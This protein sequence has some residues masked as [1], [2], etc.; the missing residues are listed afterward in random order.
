MRL[1]INISI[2][3]FVSLHGIHAKEVKSSLS[4]ITFGD[5]LDNGVTTMS[6]VIS[7]FDQYDPTWNEKFIVTDLHQ[8]VR[9][10]INPFDDV[11]IDFDVDVELSFSYKHFSFPD[12]IETQKTHTLKVNYKKDAHST[13]KQIDV[14]KLL[15]GQ[16]IEIYNIQFNVGNLTQSEIDKLKSILVLKAYTEDVR[17]YNTS[18]ISLIDDNDINVNHNQIKKEL[19]ITW[20]L[21]EAAEEYDIR[22]KFVDNYNGINNNNGPDPIPNIDLSL[23]FVPESLFRDMTRLSTSKNEITIPAIEEKSLFIVS[24]RA[25]GRMG[26]DYE[27]RFEGPWSS[28]YYHWMY[29]DEHVEDKI[30]YQSITSYAEEGKYKIVNQY[31]DGRMASRQKVT[32]LQSKEYALVQESIYDHI[33]RLAIEVL[34]APVRGP[35]SSELGSIM[36]YD[37]FNRNP[38]DDEPYHAVNF[39]KVGCLSDPDAMSSITS[40]ASHYYSSAF[41]NSLSS[42]EKESELKLIPDAFERPF[43]QTRFMNDNTNRPLAQGGVGK[44]H[45]LGTGRETEITYTTPTQSELN[46][47][48]GTEVGYSNY[49]K[50]VITED[51]NNQ[52]SIAYQDLKGNT[53]ATSLYGATDNLDTLETYKK[54]SFLDD[55]TVNDNIDYD[56]YSIEMS[57]PLF[58][59]ENN[60]SYDFNYSLTPAQFTDQTC[61]G[62]NV[63]YDCIYDLIIEITNTDCNEKILRLTQSIGFNSNQDVD[64][65]CNA[66]IWDAEVELHVGDIFR[67]PNQQD[68]LILNLILNK[69][70]YV[71]NKILK[72]NEVAADQYVD[73][74]VNDPNNT[75]IKT[76]VEWLQEQEDE[77]LDA[78]CGIDCDQ[79]DPTDELLVELCDSTNNKCKMAENAMISDFMPGGQYAIYNVNAQGEYE[80]SNALSIFAPNNVLDNGGPVDFVNIIM[81]QFAADLGGMDL[82]AVD[83]EDIITVLWQPEWSAAFLPFHPEF[84]YLQHCND[85]SA[86]YDG[87]MLTIETAAQAIAQGYLDANNPENILHLLDN[88][89]FFKDPLSQNLGCTMPGLTGSDFFFSMQNELNNF[90]VNYP[91]HLNAPVLSVYDLA[92][93][94]VCNG[95]AFDTLTNTIDPTILQN[96]QNN[97]SFTSTDPELANMLWIQIRSIY[98]SIKEKY[99]Y[100]TRSINAINDGCYN[101]C[102][103]ESPFN[104]IRNNFNQDIAINT[105]SWSFQCTSANTDI[106]FLCPDQLCN[107]VDAD[108][109]KNRIK[110]FPSAYDIPFMNQI[111]D[112][113]NP[114]SVV[115]N[116]DQPD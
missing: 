102:I 104:F 21:M 33:G 4:V 115:N 90:F 107:H 3:F 40:G 76:Q 73:N 99:E 86:Q 77:L 5:Y 27:Y 17:Y 9:L 100:Y 106:P 41:Y 55:L 98:L 57:V 30:N 64:N 28:V 113:Y 48:F 96:C 105:Q 15:G 78:P 111:D 91:P 43:S 56:D 32:K 22:F 16:Q 54:V 10:E 75:C 11:V 72:V 84:C 19:H 14:L 8:I 59:P 44:D 71:I 6:S 34:P 63:C 1:L 49:Y 67:E 95:L 36:Y 50:K 60:M 83:L 88:D 52:I 20:P 109:Y 53:I 45:H 69:G 35:T 81:T 103:G 37:N 26:V 62:T 29:V 89:P 66:S 85:C 42:I 101:G 13:F 61:L 58:V 18:E 24:V 110:R 79:I 112:I 70:N 46:R 23:P 2:V 38:A 31:F 25:V 51:P 74:Y 108:L 116:L 47:L 39:D 87:T 94:N 114:D 12:G 68:P 80:S 97:I 92:V 65:I 82:A 93:Y 7:G